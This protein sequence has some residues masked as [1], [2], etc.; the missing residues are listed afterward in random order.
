VANCCLEYVGNAIH[1]DLNRFGRGLGA[2]RDAEGGEVE[3]I[4]N[5]CYGIFDRSL[6]ANIA[7]D[8]YQAP[9]APRIFQVAM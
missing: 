5:A 2:A 1:Q 6:V 7:L 8:D 3:D 9:A 4:V